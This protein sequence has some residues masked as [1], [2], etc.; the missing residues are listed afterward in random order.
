[1]LKLHGEKGSQIVRGDKREEVGKRQVWRLLETEC[2]DPVLNLGIEEAIV[3]KVSTGEAPNTV[4]F[5]RNTGT[6][7]VIGRFQIPELEVNKEACRKYSL[8]VVR[9]FTGG[10]TVYNDGGNLNYSI[11][12]RRDN[13]IIPGIIAQITPT[14]CRGVV[15]GLRTLGLNAEFEQEGA[16]I[17]INGKKISGT[18]GIVKR[19]LVFVHGTLLISSDLSRLREVLDVPPY[20]SLSQQRRF[21]KSN[22]REVTSIE[23]E[24]GRSVTF[25]EVKDAIKV[26]FAKN[27]GIEL[28][29][30][31]M[32]GSEL[33]LSKEIAERKHS[34]IM[35][36]PSQ[37]E[38]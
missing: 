1:M 20:T 35:I 14:L 28:R 10:G 3:E 8:T 34:E 7:A 2:D 16:Y 4:R 13:P 23:A 38:Q 18:A 19:T 26:G 21:V 24:L 37:R 9:R 31:R 33:L 11:A 27:L 15:E 5:W 36:S 12:V 32:L 6:V 22:R 25:E 17:H 30:G 29:T